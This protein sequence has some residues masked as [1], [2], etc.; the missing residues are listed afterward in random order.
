[1]KK[2]SGQFAF[3]K[4]NERLILA[5]ESEKCI[6]FIIQGGFEVKNTTQNAQG[7]LEVTKITQMGTRVGYHVKKESQIELCMN[8]RLVIIYIT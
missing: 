1:M 2:G 8:T 4:E 5:L 3:T 7:G 6:I